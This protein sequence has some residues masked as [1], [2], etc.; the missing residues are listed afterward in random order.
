[1]AAPDTRGT[2]SSG[3]R[4]NLWGVSPQGARRLL[5][6]QE[7]E[8][9]RVEQETQDQLGLELSQ[10]ERLQREIETLKVRLQTVR[11][12]VEV[13]R[14]KLSKERAARAV[15]AARLLDR[16]DEKAPQQAAMNEMR[17]Q[18]VHM[19]VELQREHSALR[20]LV[21]ALYRTVANRDGIPA[22]LT[23]AVEKQA[24]A[25]AARQAESDP[26]LRTNRW[27]QFLVGKIAGRTVQTPD[28]QIIAREGDRVTA[29][30]V[31]AAES[32]GLLFDLILP[33]R[34]PPSDQD[35]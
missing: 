33:M 3:L 29:E 16:P 9:A 23:V 6:Q 5:A 25:A 15:L 4:R 19:S 30:I 18:S 12:V 20:E 35:L 21:A 17:L 28:G 10:R 22:G 11:N 13:L 8:F 1:M 31:S 27:H 14:E 32:A 7:A 26:G 24:E 2:D 34:L